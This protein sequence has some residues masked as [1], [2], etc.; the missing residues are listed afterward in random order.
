MGLYEATG[1]VTGVAGPGGQ[2]WPDGGSGHRPRLQ[3]SLKWG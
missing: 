2:R 1:A 3:W